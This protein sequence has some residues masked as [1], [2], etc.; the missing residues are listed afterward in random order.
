M[1]SNFAIAAANSMDAVTDKI[2][3]LYDLLWGWFLG[4]TAIVCVVV[5][6]PL[7]AKL[8]QSGDDEQKR[9]AAKKGLITAIVG[10]VSFFVLLWVM[11]ALIGTLST[12]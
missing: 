4:L 6:A 2:N 5:F 11:P 7:I 9:A 12:M 1:L 8:I 10:I 3:D